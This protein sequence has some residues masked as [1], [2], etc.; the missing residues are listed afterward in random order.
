VRRLT[1]GGLLVVVAFSVPLFVEL[2]TV[3]GFVGVDLP[4]VAV[5]VLAVLFYAALLLVYYL[6]QEP[7][8]ATA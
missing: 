8:A 7:S 4:W 6:G 1:K 3:A 2:R 5:G